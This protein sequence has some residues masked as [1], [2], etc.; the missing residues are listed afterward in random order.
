MDSPAISMTPS[1]GVLEAGDEA[2]R[3][4]LAAA[5]GAEQRDRLAGADG[6]AHPVDRRGRP[7]PLD[8]VAE[9]DDRL[10]VVA[11]CGPAISGRRP[12]R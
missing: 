6:E 4:R 9:L 8:D 5:A 11:A 10:G 1:S 3:R 2:Q 12:G 7:E